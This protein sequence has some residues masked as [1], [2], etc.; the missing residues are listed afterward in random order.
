MSRARPLLPP[1]K[2]DL[3]P[4]E[5][6]SEIFL[7][8]VQ[9]WAWYRDDLILVCRR[10]HAIILLIPGIHSQ[11]TIKRTTQKEEVQAFI[12]GRKSRL[13]VTVDMNDES[14]IDGDGFN[15]DTFHACFMAAAQAA[16]RW[17]SLNLISPPPR[18]EYKA[19]QILQPLVHL[20]SFKLACGFGEFV[21]PLMTAISRSAS[22]NFNTM[23][24]EDP[25]AVLY[26]V[27]PTCLQ[28]NHSLR[29]LKIQ[30]S[31]RMNITADVL[32]HLHRLEIFEARH[33]CLPFYPPDASL[34][35]THTLRFLHLKSVSV[36]WMAGHIFP[37]L[38]ECHVIFPHHAG[39]VQALQPVT[40]PFC[41]YLLYHSN[42]LRPLTHLHL[43][44]LYKLEVKS[45]QW[46]A[47][48]GNPQ[49][50]ALRPVVAAAAKSL[51]VLHLDVECSE[52]L[53]VYMLSLVPALDQLRLGLARP[54]TLTATFFRALIVGEPNAD[55]ASDMVG[56][57]SRA[58]VPLCPSLTSLYLQYR[59]WLRGPDNRAL[60]AIFGDI[61]VSRNL[62][63]HRSFNLWL[64]LDEAS[65]SSWSIDKP[66]KNSQDL[67][68]EDLMLGILVPHG[69]VPIS[70]AFPPNG[71]VALPLKEAEYL[72][73]RHFH[74]PSSVEF[75][76][77]HDN[78]ELVVYDYDRALLPTSLPCALPL[79]Y[80]LRV[81]VME[82]VN[83]SFLAGH[84]FHKLEKCRVV[85]SHN[86]FGA[87]P[88]LFTE[89]EMPVCTRVD[90]DD[91]YLL[92]TFRLPQI[93][94]LA[95]TFSH[96][97]SSIIWEKHIM[98]NANLSGLNLLHMKGWPFDGDLIPIL[99]SLPLLETL[100]I[101]SRRGVVSFRPF[102]PMD[103]NETSGLEETS[104]E[105]Q[106][107]VLLCPRLRSLQIEWNALS[108]QPEL[109][110]ILNDVVTLRSECGSPLK[111]FTFS[112]FSCK[113][114]SKLQLIGSGG[115]F[116]MEILFWSG[117]LMRSLMRRPVDSN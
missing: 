88:S 89:T 111:S 114:R 18:E 8:T 38:K 80:A 110:P 13:D 93:Y 33:L 5:I 85:K 24:L 36:Q 60:I 104:G 107:L 1:G 41:S 70:T 47:W 16:S 9:G 2:A 7:F 97:N 100:I 52:K 45:G 6:L 4:V 78:M 12:Q 68:S 30:L 21:E 59:R 57:L 79:F 71:V 113:P 25:I 63:I 112:K 86:S 26:L 40:M 42:D 115:R 95:L 109:I 22:P 53:L 90:I 15:T 84:T 61:M 116:T 99:R 51:T 105:G 3:I 72:H 103:A 102:L 67:E 65:K 117:R 55:D 74:F 101:S 73:L 43:P 46:N 66:V 56:P 34:P 44:S 108:M 83:H 10:W 32:P 28:I 106:M 49:L 96:P 11:L 81:L 20:K 91:P 92:A 58:I 23:Y 64:S 27:Q 87:S 48:R 19:L 69:I 76:F 54:N 37:A 75:L 98:M 94:E 82:G 77:T 29:T 35:L 17:R 14:A 31:K 50:S 62:E 39:M